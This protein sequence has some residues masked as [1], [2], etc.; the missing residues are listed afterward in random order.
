MKRLFHFYAVARLHS[1]VTGLE[2]MTSSKFM[3]DFQAKLHRFKVTLDAYQA[4]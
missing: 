2:A 3:M 1:P 4:K